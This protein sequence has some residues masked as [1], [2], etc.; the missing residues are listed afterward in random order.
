[1][2]TSLALKVDNSATLI[3]A[4]QPH[5]VRRHAGA[6]VVVQLFCLAFAPHMQLVKVIHGSWYEATHAGPIRGPENCNVG[7]SG[8]ISAIKKSVNCFLAPTK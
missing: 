8:L 1:M 3:V 4:A 6:P 7:L 2:T 5:L